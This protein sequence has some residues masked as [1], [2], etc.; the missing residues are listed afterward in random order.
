MRGFIAEYLGLV[1]LVKCFVGESWFTRKTTHKSRDKVPGSPLQRR[2]FPDTALAARAPR[3]KIQL[4][5][6]AGVFA[7][8]TAGTEVPVCLE[9]WVIISPGAL[10]GHLS[11]PEPIRMQ[12]CPTGSRFSRRCDSSLCSSL[13]VWDVAGSCGMP[14][15]GSPLP[16]PQLSTRKR[17][18]EKSQP[19]L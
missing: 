2:P 17:R 18:L 12:G 7:P 16:W 14:C 13:L 4:A 1:T 6:S 5:S 8:L 9:G 19:Q 15:L 11:L 10:S 3:L